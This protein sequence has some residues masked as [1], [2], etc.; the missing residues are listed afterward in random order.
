MNLDRHTLGRAFTTSLVTTQ[1][2]QPDDLI[3][4]SASGFL[5]EC[6]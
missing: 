3:E 4:K 5:L 6:V 2:V 1:N